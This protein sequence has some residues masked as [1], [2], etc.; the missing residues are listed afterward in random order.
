VPFAGGVV[1]APGLGSIVGGDGDTDGVG[2]GEGVV[3]G[4]GV[5]DGQDRPG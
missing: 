5:G 3:A 4:A 2:V 1:P